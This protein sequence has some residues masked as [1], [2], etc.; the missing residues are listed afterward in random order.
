MIHIYSSL[1]LMTSVKGIS[2]RTRYK[3]S[4][5]AWKDYGRS[6]SFPARS[7]PPST[8]SVSIRMPYALNNFLGAPPPS[9]YSSSA[10][11][12]YLILFL[13]H[14]GILESTMARVRYYLP[15]LKYRIYLYFPYLPPFTQESSDVSRCM[16]TVSVTV[17]SF[18]LTCFISGSRRR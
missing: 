15:D 4:L 8:V 18:L 10:S 1:L 5:A 11:N 16:Y 9:I 13:L 6:P 7:V 3:N 12:I 17:G 14:T 2:A